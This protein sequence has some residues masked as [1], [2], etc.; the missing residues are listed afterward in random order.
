[1]KNIKDDSPNQD[2][3]RHLEKLLDDAKKGEI[4]SMVYVTGFDDNCCS[5]GWAVDQRTYRNMLLGQF[6]QLQTDFSTNVLLDNEESV[7]SR[8]LNR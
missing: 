7:I 2:L 8:A 1:M 5:H 3:I 4:I 6:V